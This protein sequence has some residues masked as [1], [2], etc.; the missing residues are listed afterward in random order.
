M[1]VVSI[2]LTLQ[3]L[4]WC[5]RLSDD[6]AACE[7]DTAGTCSFSACDQSLGQTECKGAKCLCKSGTCS[8]NGKCVADEDPES[9]QAISPE[10]VS[11]GGKDAR[12]TALKS[13]DLDQSV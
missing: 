5:V 1:K 3:Q 2:F 4:S 12:S 7:K 6:Q 10:L 13:I 11:D 8:V 9:S